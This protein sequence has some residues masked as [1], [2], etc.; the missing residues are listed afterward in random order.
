MTPK[1]YP[2]LPPGVRRCVGAFRRPCVILTDA[3]LCPTCQAV[4]DGM[5]PERRDAIARAPTLTRA[6]W[7]RA[8]WWTAS[9]LHRYA[10]HGYPH[11]TLGA[12][13]GR[14]GYRVAG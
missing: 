11:P 1:P 10:R 12:R 2:A 6:G 8:S 13:A 7:E 4:I 3:I 14:D 5:D 9:P